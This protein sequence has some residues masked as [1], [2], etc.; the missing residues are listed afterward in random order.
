MNGCDWDAF[1]ASTTSECTI[2]RVL[3]A[4][5]AFRAIQKPEFDCVVTTAE[6][7]RKLRE[8]VNEHHPCGYVCSLDFQGMEIISCKDRQEAVVLAMVLVEKGRRPMLVVGDD[9]PV[10][11][12]ESSPSG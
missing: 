1:S 5:A 6:L 12:V 7:Y 4:M 3:E 10:E 2:E 9:S 8:V 11:G